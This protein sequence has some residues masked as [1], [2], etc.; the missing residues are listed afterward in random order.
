[1]RSLLSVAHRAEQRKQEKAQTYAAGALGAAGV[2]AG[3]VA[4]GLMLL[5]LARRS[6]GVRARDAQPLEL[7]TSVE[8]VGKATAEDIL[9]QIKAH[10]FAGSDYLSELV[11]PYVAKFAPRFWRARRYV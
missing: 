3:T 2:A 6:R 9:A 5:E 7:D 4:G 8:S 11:R 1:M 10:M